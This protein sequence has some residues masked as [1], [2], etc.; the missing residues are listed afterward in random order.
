MFLD[1]I[2]A[3][4]VTAGVG[5]LGTDLFLSSAAI[6]PAG[7]GPYISIQETGGSAPTR[8][9]NQ[10]GAKTQRPTA[11]LLIRA[12]TFP[13]ARTKAKSAY[14]ALD[15]QFNVTLNGIYYLSITAR[16]EPTDLGLDGSGRPQ[17]VFNIDAEKS[18]S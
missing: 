17:V 13:T 7:N 4:L 6:V 11:Q 8:V 16:Q 14:D 9:Q 15:G 1:D 2:A 18:P 12:S 10:A 3:R 5:T